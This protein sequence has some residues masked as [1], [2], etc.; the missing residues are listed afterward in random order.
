MSIK[1]GDTFEIKTGP[2]KKRRGDDDNCKE[3]SGWGQ[4][5]EQETSSSAEPM[6]FQEWFIL[7]REGPVDEVTVHYGDLPSLQ[8][9]GIINLSNYMH[10]SMIPP[11]LL[12]EAS[13]VI[14]VFQTII[15]AKSKLYITNQVIESIN[16][17][18]CAE[19]FFEAT[20]TKLDDLFVNAEEELPEFFKIKSDTFD[21][22]SNGQ[23]SLV[24][25]SA[26]IEQA[27][28]APRSQKKPVVQNSNEVICLD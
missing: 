23:V 17:S 25:P 3:N 8:M 26:Y 14:R 6:M 2:F 11:P 10:L 22:S 21:L 13:Y 4:N 19:E 18:D 16:L 7:E 15:S 1:E 20:N 28:K 24:S 27:K 5:S 9:L 12:E